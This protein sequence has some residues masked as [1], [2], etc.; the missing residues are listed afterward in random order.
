MC[1]WR[2]DRGRGRR[3]PRRR[4]LATLAYIRDSAR[5][6]SL[7][8]IHDSRSPY[9]SSRTGTLLPRTH[10]CGRSASTHLPFHL[11]Y[12]YLVPSLFDPQ[13]ASSET[14]TDVPE[15]CADASLSRLLPSS[16]HPLRPDRSSETK[17]YPTRFSKARA[18]VERQLRH[19]RAL[20]SLLKGSCANDVNAS[21]EK[22]S[23]VSFSSIINISW[24]R[25]LLLTRPNTFLSEDLSPKPTFAH[26][27]I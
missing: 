1:M 13:T 26:S 9:H 25:P 14:K 10:A 22:M 2:E 11:V 7:F 6:Q 27:S 16:T 12:F 17:I 4:S 8:T 23:M 15:A 18:P 24:R 5:L 20:R 3:M 19:L 21:M